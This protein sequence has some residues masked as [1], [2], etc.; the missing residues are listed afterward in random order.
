MSY[1][2]VSTHIHCFRLLPCITI[3]LD[4]L[5]V[6]A[7]VLMVI[8]LLGSSLLGAVNVAQKLCTDIYGFCNQCEQIWRFIGLWATFK[9]FWQHLIC[10][11]LSHSKGIFVKGSKSIIFLVKSG[12]GKFYRHLAIFFWSHCL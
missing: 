6:R 12:L 10:P 3:R 8:N 9:C 5:Q 7:V 2:S 1:T 4:L 11:N